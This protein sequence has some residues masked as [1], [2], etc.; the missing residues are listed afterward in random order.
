[1]I[2][3][4]V[5][6][7][8]PRVWWHALQEAL[9]NKGCGAPEGFFYG[10]Y[11]PWEYSHYENWTY[12]EILKKGTYNNIFG[13][14]IHDT[15]FIEEKGSR[16]DIFKEILSD[17]DTYIIFLD[18]KN[19]LRQAISFYIACTS[20]KFFHNEV[21]N[22]TDVVPYSFEKINIYHKQ[23]GEKAATL[24]SWIEKYYHK[25]CLY[26]S[27]EDD[28]NKNPYVWAQKVMDYIW[29]TPQIDIEDITLYNKKA[30]PKMNELFYNRFI[31]TQK[32]Y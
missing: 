2:K 28:I 23:L 5:I 4:Y 3:K 31:S 9:R 14:K 13:C 12:D 8:S 26:L 32:E 10:T 21:D 19:I 20:R 27:Y 15:D 22:N 30:F 7:T 6:I 1:M 29:Y 17:K 16:L 25:K 11:S 24:R 18:R